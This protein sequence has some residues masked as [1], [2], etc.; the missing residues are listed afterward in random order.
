MWKMQESIKFRSDA[1]GKK[2]SVVTKNT[3]IVAIIFVLAILLVKISYDYEHITRY[4]KDIPYIERTMDVKDNLIRDYLETRMN[5]VAQTQDEYQY[6][7]SRKI[8]ILEER[9]KKLE[10]KMGNNNSNK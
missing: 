10:N 5:R 6:S 3:Y 4:A 1:M 8:Q 9:I 2:K 7:T